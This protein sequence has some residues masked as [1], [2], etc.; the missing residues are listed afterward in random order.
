VNEIPD[1]L[2]FDLPYVSQTWDQGF[3]SCHVWA[4]YLEKCFFLQGGSKEFLLLLLQ[5]G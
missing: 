4:I 1:T 2:D 5:I 3:G